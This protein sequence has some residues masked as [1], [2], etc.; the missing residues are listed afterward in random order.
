MQIPSTKITGNRINSSQFSSGFQVSSASQVSSVSSVSCS[1]PNSFPLRDT[2]IPF[3]FSKKEYS[4]ILRK[5]RKEFM[6]THF[7]SSLSN[8][9]RFLLEDAHKNKTCN[10][11]IQLTV[12]EDLDVHRTEQKI[13]LYFQDLGYDCLPGLRKTNDENLERIL[14]FTLT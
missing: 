10:L 2:S 4:N 5:K 12:P 1:C 3:E 6:Y 11:E 8:I 13:R 14:F 9:F 7:S